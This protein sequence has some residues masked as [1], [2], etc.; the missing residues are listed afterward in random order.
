L[1]FSLQFLGFLFE[2]GSRSVKYPK[3]PGGGEYEI[4]DD[5]YTRNAN[6]RPS[7]SFSD[8]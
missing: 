2:F 5:N 6:V 1:A 8:G 7:I 3:S 4:I